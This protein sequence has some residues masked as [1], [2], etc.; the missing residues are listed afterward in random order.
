MTDG[1]WKSMVLEALLT[2]IRAAG[3]SEASSA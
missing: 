3:P 1:Y 2:R